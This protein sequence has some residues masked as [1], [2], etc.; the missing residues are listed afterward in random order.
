MVSKGVIVWSGKSASKYTYSIYPLDV[1]FLNRAGNYVFVKETEP[2]TFLAIYVGETS[3]LS[4]GFD[5]HPKMP[6]ITRHGATHITA[7]TNSGTDSDRRAE[8]LDLI[9]G[10]DPPCND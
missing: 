6:C 9:Q 8:E 5:S 10:L 7:H 4:E 1:T 2:K 3:D